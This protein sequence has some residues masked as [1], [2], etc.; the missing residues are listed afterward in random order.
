[1]SKE[2]PSINE[3]KNLGSGTWRVD[4]FG[5]IERN[6]SVP[7]EFAFR[8][9]LSKLKDGWINQDV[10]TDDAVH[11][12]SR[13][14]VLIGAGQLP[15]IFIGSFWRDG[16]RLPTAAGQI[17]TLDLTIEPSTTE[18]FKSTD[19]VDDQTLVPFSSHQVGGAGKNSWCITI[20][21]NGDSA[22]VIVPAMEVIRFYYA[23]SSRLSKAVFDGSFT[24]SISSLINPKYTGMTS[25]RCVVHRRR[26]VSDNDCWTIGRILNSQEAAASVRLIHDSLIK[27]QANNIEAFPEA[28]F[29]FSGKTILR[30]RCK[31]IGWKKKRWLVLSL[32]SCSGPFPYDELEV[33]PDNG[34]DKANPSTDIPDEEK[35]PAWSGKRL[36]G[37]LTDDVTLQSLHEPETNIE[38]YKIDLSENRFSAIKDKK[39]IKTVKEECPYKAGEL[40]TIVTLGECGIL[41][42]GDGTHS[43]TGVTPANVDILGDRKGLPASL[44]GLI[45]MLTVLNGYPGISAKLHSFPQGEG[46]INASLTN[47]A[48]RRQWSYLH[49]R[50]RK[51][52]HFMVAAIQYA[53]HYFTL[54]EVE[55]REDSPSDT[56]LAEI[57]FH[58]DGRAISHGELSAIAEKLSRV[59]GRMKHLNVLPNKI[60]RF[61]EGR[62]HTWKDTTEYAQSIASCLE[63]ARQL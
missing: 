28:G 63:L 11:S 52:R 9:I 49:Y 47:R 59:G 20:A 39:I 13:R 5:A 60:R 37:N 25:S 4:W 15:L 26:D 44:N 12:E 58:A 45:A 40:T 30:A 57:L 33:I 24:H 53:G 46:L 54:I 38:T 43:Q 16:C 55:R 32:H 23:T 14:S 51:I 18:I 19:K 17:Q 48:D 50:T 62:K 2:L 3:I 29:P 1:M 21:Y 56:Y 34:G 31:Q 35:K 8:V 10:A 27:A 61:G 42:T 6:Q 41:G 22:G 36:K 7:T